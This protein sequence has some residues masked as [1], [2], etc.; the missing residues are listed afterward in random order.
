[1]ENKTV[2]SGPSSIVVGTDFNI[3]WDAVPNAESYHIMFWRYKDGTTIQD[4]NYIFGGTSQVALNYPIPG[5]WIPI[6]GK[7]CFRITSYAEG[8]VDSISTFEIDVTGGQQT[9]TGLSINAVGTV[10]VNSSF[11]ATWSSVANATSY[12]VE[13]IMPYDVQNDLGSRGWTCSTNETTVLSAYTDVIGTNILRVTAVASSYKSIME[14]ITFA[15][16]ATSTVTSFTMSK[17]AVQT[18]ES[19]DFTV[20]ATGASKVRLV[21]GGLEY[22][23]YDLVAGVASFSRSFTDDGERKIQFQAFKDGVGGPL[24]TAQTLTVMAPQGTLAAPVIDAISDKFVNERVD[25]SWAPVE[26]AEEYTVYV[27]LNGDEKWH[28]TTSGETISIPAD[29]MSITSVAG[30]YTL[31]V[32]ATAQGYSQ[33]EAGV[34]FNMKNPSVRIT[35][36]QAARDPRYVIGDKIT[37]IVEAEGVGYVELMVSPSQGEPIGMDLQPDGTL[38]GYPTAKSEGVNTLQAIGYVSALEKDTPICTSATVKVT[39]EG[40]KI[41]SLSVSSDRNP[42]YTRDTYA[43]GL[44]GTTFKFT[45]VTNWGVPTVIASGNRRTPGQIEG[46]L[47]NSANYS[48]TFTFFDQPDNSNQEYK[49]TFQT[50]GEGGS[51]D[52]RSFIVYAVSQRYEGTRYTG[53][54]VEF[55]SRPGVR[56]GTLELNTKITIIG[57]YRDYY[58]VEVEGKN[59]GLLIWLDSSLFFE[60]N[61]DSEKDDTLT[62]LYNFGELNENFG[63]WRIM[64]FDH[65]AILHYYIKTLQASIKDPLGAALKYPVETTIKIVTG[66]NAENQKLIA[67]FYEEAALQQI[68]LLSQT[69]S[70]NKDVSVK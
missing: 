35:V 14:Q 4:T 30:V 68:Y 28:G 32:C 69:I 52:S 64:D 63:L 50:S 44:V 62:A 24:C 48:H 53:E 43:F 17:T 9:L 25:V 16:Q 11:T 15:V 1:M 57:T 65:M 66:Q 51:S 6:P 55:Y 26:H 59:G 60:K 58:F 2:I 70:Y 47:E 56:A 37:V 42:E 41:R 23:E 12:Y 46:V 45:I 61:D 67:K 10:P 31:V 27:Y 38:L 13:I 34:V 54:G 18:R 40:V 22:D 39:V 19:V 36:S 7:Y 49:Y 5:T 33:S 21:V 3:S 20:N 29:T 8:Y